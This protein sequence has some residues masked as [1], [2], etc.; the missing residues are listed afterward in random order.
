MD[1]FVHSH[2]SQ[3]CAGQ[4]G[5]V[6]LLWSSYT[7]HEFLESELFIPSPSSWPSSWVEP[8][9]KVI[10]TLITKEFNVSNQRHQRLPRTVRSLFRFPL[11]GPL[12]PCDVPVNLVVKPGTLT[13]HK[14]RPLGTI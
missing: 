13:A 14:E 6:N 5:G 7:S 11:S 12:T 2:R 1:V 4:G 3:C 10:S 8:I 9:L